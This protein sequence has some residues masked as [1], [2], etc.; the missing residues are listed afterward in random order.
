[1]LVSAVLKIQAVVHKCKLASDVT[2]SAVQDV[3][4]EVQKSKLESE[5]RL[6][7]MRKELLATEDKERSEL[8]HEYRSVA[9]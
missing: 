5:G 1:M 3:E 2:V 7:A 9:C 8:E 6:A 4:A